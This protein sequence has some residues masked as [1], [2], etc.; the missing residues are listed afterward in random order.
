ML[1]RPIHN[2]KTNRDSLVDFLRGLRHPK[3]ATSAAIRELSAFLKRLDGFGSASLIHDR[4]VQIRRFQ[5]RSKTASPAAGIELNCATHRGS[6]ILIVELHAKIGLNDASGKS[7]D[8]SSGPTFHTGRKFEGAAR[9]TLAG[10]VFNDIDRS[11]AAIL[12]D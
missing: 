8:E 10:K 6:L 2:I 4:R 12:P 11:S 5:T 9:F 1:I 7:P 3:N